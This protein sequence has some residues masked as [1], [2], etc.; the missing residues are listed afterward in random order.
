MNQ[1]GTQL[2]EQ[3]TVLDPTQ[4]QA[5]GTD[6]FTQMGELAQSQIDELT[7]QLAGTDLV[8]ETYLEKVGRINNAR[9]R[10]AEMIMSEMP[11][12]VDRFEWEHRFEIWQGSHPIRVALREFHR[13]M[14]EI[15]DRTVETLEDEETQ[16]ADAASAKT[17]LR[18]DLERENLPSNLIAEC[19][20]AWQVPSGTSE[21]LVGIWKTQPS[22]DRRI[23]AMLRP[24]WEALSIETRE[25]AWDAASDGADYYQ[26]TQRVTQGLPRF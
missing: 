5:M 12:P 10:A 14:D 23:E 15:E 22:T 8:N 25:T 6:Y 24:L 1:Y 2:Q 13:T 16:S 18:T 17:W 26:A 21:Q 9:T 7:I 3:W 11:R 19:L 4:A 20:E